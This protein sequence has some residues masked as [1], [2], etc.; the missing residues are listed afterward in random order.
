MALTDQRL[1]GPASLTDERV[2]GTVAETP[3]AETGLLARTALHS[4]RLNSG[5]K[6]HVKR[7]MTKC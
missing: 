1:T 4:R 2:D 6:R 3:A 7:Q 5:K